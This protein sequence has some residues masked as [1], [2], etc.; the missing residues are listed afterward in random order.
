MTELCKIGLFEA[1]SENL[2]LF[3]LSFITLNSVMLSYVRLR[4][5]R[6]SFLRCRFVRLNLNMEDEEQ[7]DGEE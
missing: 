6:L 1:K 7:E 2:I 5:A 3:R 4:L